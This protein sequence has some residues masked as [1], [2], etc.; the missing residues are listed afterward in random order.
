MPDLPRRRLERALA[1][2]S[3]AEL[4]RA[5]SGLRALMSLMTHMAN[6]GH[7][8]LAT[9]MGPQASPV[10][11]WSHWPPDDAC[12]TRTGYRWYY[13]CHA[14][15]G[16]TVGEHGHFHLFSEPRKG[17][18]VTHLVAVSVDARGLP[19][20]LFAPNRWVTDERWQ[21]APRVLRLIEAFAMKAPRALRRIHD[22]LAAVLRACA[23]QVRA[24]LRHRDER[25]HVL[26]T[27]KG[28]DVM[29]DRRIA[30]FSRC[31]IDL[32]SQAAVLDRR[33]A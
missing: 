4:R 18:G 32:Q 24:L 28:G 19:L 10:S 30:V 20:G 1:E 5:A 17:E 16:R 3:R 27:R 13:H 6:E 14:R 22:W 29:E 33:L 7:N 8:V 11:A 31:A 15:D 9:A 25:M 2:E 21:P 26:R 23:P 12:D